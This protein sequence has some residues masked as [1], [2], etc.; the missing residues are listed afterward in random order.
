M[1]VSGLGPCRWCIKVDKRSGLGCGRG[2]SMGAGKDNVR[3]QANYAQSVAQQS[4]AV[5]SEG[6]T[7][8]GVNS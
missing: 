5:V 6:D 7:S 2:D 8:R 4:D 3:R 1:S